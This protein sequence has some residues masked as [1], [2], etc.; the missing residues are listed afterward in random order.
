MLLQLVVCVLVLVVL[1]VCGFEDTF[2]NTQ[3]AAIHFT[4]PHGSYL[5]EVIHR[6]GVEVNLIGRKETTSVLFI[7][8]LLSHLFSPF[9]V[10]TMFSGICFPFPQDK[11]NSNQ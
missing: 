5:G 9:N 11:N 3:R 4:K 8:Y 10:C 6:N 2:S 7:I 1:Y